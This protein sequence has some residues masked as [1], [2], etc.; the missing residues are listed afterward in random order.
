M[1]LFSWLVDARWTSDPQRCVAA[2]P[3]MTS[4]GQT[5]YLISKQRC[6]Q[7]A[8]SLCA[9]LRGEVREQGGQLS[10]SR[11]HQI[12]VVTPC[13]F[14]QDPGAFMGTN[15]RKPPCSGYARIQA[16]HCLV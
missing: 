12:N 13:R 2:K 1:N 14:F 6:D 3:Q 11:L 7:E 5:R 10:R 4:A 15:P 16:L 8:E 9:A